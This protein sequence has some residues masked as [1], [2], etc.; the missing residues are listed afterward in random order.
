MVITEI[1]QGR[2][3]TKL[4][5][6]RI[7]NFMVSSGTLLVVLS[8]MFYLKDIVQDVLFLSYSVPFL[9]FGLTIFYLD[10]FQKYQDFFLP[11]LLI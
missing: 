2:A 1:K 4:L 8:E 11:P 9:W 5:E 3:S 6:W 10:N 7:C